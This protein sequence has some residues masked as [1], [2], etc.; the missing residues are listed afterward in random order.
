MTKENKRLI[1]FFLLLSIFLL[2]ILFGLKF[3]CP[4]KSIFNISCP[5]CGLTRSITSLLQ[6]NILDRLYYNILGIPLFLFFITSYLLIV[7]DIIKKRNYLQS[8]LHKLS[9]YYLVIIIFLI[10]TFILNNI[11]K[12]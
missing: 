4:I 9:K 8:F 5:G 1:I 6:L 2:L 3:N 10:I 11:H 7:I 12:I